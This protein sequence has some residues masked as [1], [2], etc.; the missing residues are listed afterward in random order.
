MND[1][2]IYVLIALLPL[3]A[4][5]VVSQANPY[6]ALV[7][8]GVLGAMAAMI[9]AILGAAD[10]ALTEALVGTMLAISLY[11]IAVRSSL[12]MRLGVLQDE[13]VEADNKTPPPGDFGQLVDNF[14]KIFRKRQMRLELIPYPNSQALERALMD[15]EVHATI[16]PDQTTSED[17]NH[18]YHTVIR[19]KRIYDI[20]QTE[21]ASPATTLSYVSTSNSEEKQT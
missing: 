11:A 21:L 5:L 16:H 4:F 3:S 12:V 6:Y 18:S 15:K 2:Y 13:L 20:M 8:R 19:V 7:I 1:S 14:R 9:Y 17:E 10:V